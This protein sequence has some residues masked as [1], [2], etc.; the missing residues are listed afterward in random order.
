[1]T[2]DRSTADPPTALKHRGTGWWPNRLY[3][4]LLVHRGSGCVVA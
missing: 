2:S 3:V 1:M 4:C